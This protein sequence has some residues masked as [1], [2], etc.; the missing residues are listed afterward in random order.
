MTLYIKTNSDGDPIYPYSPSQLR[1]DFPDTSFPAELP[2]ERLADWGVFPVLQ[3]EP[4]ATGAGQVAEQVAPDLVDSAWTLQWA[5]RDRTIEELAAAKLALVEQVK[6]RRDQAIEAGC[7]VDGIGT[8]DTDAV[9]RSNI[10]GA[11][12][13]A[14]I[15][16]LAEQPF[17]IGWKLADNSIVQLNGPQMIAV[18]VAVLTRVS[19]AHANAQALGTAI[20]AAGDFAALD[21]IDIGAGW[22]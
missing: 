2:D 16:Q 19:A 13:G 7:G 22:P 18:G 11:V 3:A 6:A 1:Y 17:A 15:A 21:A 9:S 14:M 10:N 4:P 20:G 8:F 5:V 12:T